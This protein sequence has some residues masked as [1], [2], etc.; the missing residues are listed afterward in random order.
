MIPSYLFLDEDLLLLSS[1]LL[2]VFTLC[3]T[4]AEEIVYIDMFF[5]L[6]GFDLGYLLFDFMFFTDR[7]L[8]TSLPFDFLLGLLSYGILLGLTENLA[9]SSVLSFWGF[10]NIVL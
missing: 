7:D 1:F 8:L 3:I 6:L 4:P 10:L 5:L 9:S 2:I